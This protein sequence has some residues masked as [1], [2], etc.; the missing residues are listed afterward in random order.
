MPLDSTTPGDGGPLSPEQQE[1]LAQASARAKK[2]LRAARVATFNGWFLGVFAALTLPFA[3][4][5]SVT[6]LVMG[7][8]MAI[9]ARNEFHGRK[10]LRHFD[11]RG[12]RLLGRNQLCF[13]GLL[14]GYCLWS[15]YRTLTE[16]MTQLQE[17]EVIAGSVGDLATSLTVTVYGIVIFSSVLFQGLNARYYFAR[18][19]MVQDYLDETPPWIIDVQRSTSVL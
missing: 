18:T 10:L 5:F 4:F 14:I 9:L 2:V 13:M 1:E 8:S 15:I 7:V 6:A 16:P 12:P 19:K 17:L 11:P 3:L